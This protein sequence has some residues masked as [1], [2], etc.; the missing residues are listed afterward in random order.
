M[1]ILDGEYDQATPVAD[2]RRAA[3]A[4]PDSTFVEVHNTGHISAL[5]DFG[6]CASGIV[7]RFLTTLDAGDTSCAA[8]TPIVTVV[9]SFPETLAAARG[10]TTPQRAAWVAGQVVGD[11]F[12]RWWNLMSTTHGIGLRGGGFT[13]K[14]PYTSL[15][16]L[17][18]IFHDD[19]FVNDL[20]VSGTAVFDRATDSVHATLRLTGAA[21][22]RL[23][24]EFA[25][26]TPGAMAT[27]TGRLGG[28]AV[29]LK[30]PA[31]WATQG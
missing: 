2:A 14:G 27:V 15:K 1:L 19:R 7:R 9:P 6:G 26:D 29:S 24:L 25:T 16:P 13:V 18:L 31:P 21:N 12:S 8:N 10:A 3:Q 20:A 28:T 11:G 17:S 30:T 5:D 4:W 23:T 22:G